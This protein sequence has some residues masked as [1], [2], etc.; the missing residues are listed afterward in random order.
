MIKESPKTIV[1]TKLLVHLE[2]LF[3]WLYFLFTRMLRRVSRPISAAVACHAAAS[4]GA[5]T[6]QFAQV[7]RHMSDETHDDFKPKVKVDTS[8]K[9]EA[10]NTI[11]KVGI[12]NTRLR[13]MTYAAS[14]D[15]CPS[16]QLVTD[17]CI[18]LFMKGT[19]EQPMC[20]FSQQVVR[21]LHS[22]GACLALCPAQ[23][24]AQVVT[25][26]AHAAPPVTLLLFA[27]ALI[28]AA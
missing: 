15:H 8:D 18:F 24:Q 28:S 7:V 22:H 4:V 14:L 1:G 17:H 20:G 26:H 19:P 9:S 2:N 25:P 27:Q 16:V 13:N 5:A 6:S 3:D 12:R 11:Q 21:I 10:H 23:Q